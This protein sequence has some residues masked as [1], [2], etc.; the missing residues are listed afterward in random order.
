VTFLAT[1]RRFPGEPRFPGLQAIAM[2]EAEVERDGKTSRSD[3]SISVRSSWMQACS[4]APPVPTGVENCLH[5]V[6]DVVFHDDLSRLRSGYGPQNM[7]TVRHIA[8]NLLRAA[9]DH[10]SLKLRCKSAGWDLNYLETILRR[11]A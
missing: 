9:N 11:S 1:D 8:L 6:L 2:V 7:A 4:P 10:H 3:A 5:W